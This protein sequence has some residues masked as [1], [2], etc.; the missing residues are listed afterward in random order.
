MNHSWTAYLPAFLRKRLDGRQEL[1]RIV[2]N[3]GW[4]F[5]D[6][7]LRLGVGFFV[8]V[9]LARYLGPDR[10]GLL[11][12]ATAFAALF[13]SLAA[14]G[15]EGIVVREVVREPANRG[16]ILGSAFVLRLAGG[17]LA[18]AL[19]VAAVMLLRPGDSLVVWLVVVV[20]AGTVFQSF[21]VID[22][23]F[24]S[25]VESKYSVWARNSAFLLIAL[26]KVAL[27]LLM[28][29]LLAFAAAGLAEAVLA[30]LGL[31]GVY[32]YSGQRPGSWRWSRPRAMRL[33]RDSWPLCLGALSIAVYM[34]IDQVML[35]D[36]AGDKAVGIYSAAVR[37]TEAWYCIPVVVVSSVFPAILQSRAADEAFY[38]RRLQ[39]LFSLMAGISLSIAVPV[40]FLS[41]WL[42]TLLF[43]A[44]FAD[45]GPVLA[46]YIWASFFV[47]LGVA[48]G[49]WDLAEN[50]TGL[51]LFRL[52]SGAG[53]N[54]VLNV[55]LIPAYGVMGAAAATVISQAFSAVVL[56]V[57]HVKTR[58]IFYMQMN[59]LLFFRYLRKA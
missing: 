46:I 32:L 22:Y 33:L 50:L 49:A 20:A 19:T 48:Q 58:R 47:F 59:S 11:S 25:R 56:N 27:I 7:A 54:I 39:R 1:Q 23:W 30:A 38:Y 53:L 36:M 45:A 15:H 26:L 3:S 29:P 43:G 42:V 8:S 18:A 28:A 13:A 44:G 5:A 6:K 41:G 2:G 37:L 35:G 21:D 4:L 14:L 31:L 55:F 34:R 51:M 57:V 40:S 17:G 12:Y 52:A 9:W 24:Q 10:F 16:E